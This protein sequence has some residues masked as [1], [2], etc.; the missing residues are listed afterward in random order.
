MPRRVRD[1]LTTAIVSVLLVGGSGYFY[2][3]HVQREA[4]HR[5]CELL[6]V[7]TGGPPPVA[8]PAGDR[9]RELLGLLTR[10]RNDLGC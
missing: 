6:T 5:W 9:A 3:N 2:T 10:L 4:D 7:L 1:A 8:G